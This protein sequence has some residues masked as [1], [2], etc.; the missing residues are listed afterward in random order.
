MQKKVPLLTISY[1]RTREQK[2]FYKL[3][4]ASWR[5]NTPIDIENEF[6]YLFDY[7]HALIYQAQTESDLARL[8]QNC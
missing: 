6:G 1:G 3:W 7:V 8:S 4:L 2:E 5:N